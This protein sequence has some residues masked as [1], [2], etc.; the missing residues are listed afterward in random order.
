[1]FLSRFDVSRV[2]WIIGATLAALMLAGCSMVR[3]GYS[4]AP[5]LAYWWIDG[6]AD[7]SG[8]Q[9]PRM[10]DALDQWFD[11]HRRTQL[12]DYAALLQRAQAEVLQP[13]TPQAMCGW[14]DA[15]Q[16]RLDVALE[17]ATPALAALMVTL[18]PE[19]LRHIE[20]KQAKEGAEL[21]ADFTQGDRA[22]RAKASFKRTL[23]RFEML[24]GALDEPQRGRLTQLLAQSSFDADRWLAE[25]ER[26]NRDMLQTLTQVSTAART[27]DRTAA[28]TQAEAAVRMLAERMQ[29]SSRPDYRTY[30]ERLT[31][32]NCE[33]VAT[34]HNQTTP[35]QRQHARRKLRSW[36]EDLRL[37]VVSGA[38]GSLS[39]GSRAPQ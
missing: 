27:I 5:S 39:G 32:E 21:R 12:P 23:E 10:R 2:R 28:Q 34:M 18:S 31:L 15:V 29:R 30:Q 17:Q 16:K 22:E 33:L 11:W 14:R 36:E 26:R 37:L 35:V 3:L 13:T 9:T 4:Q 25:R 24:Y 19:Q 1:M 8:E 7:L 20:R 38:T 6:Y